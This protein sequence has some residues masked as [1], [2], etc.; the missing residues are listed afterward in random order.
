[1]YRKKLKSGFCSLLATL[2][3]GVFIF[4]ACS[5][6]TSEEFKDTDSSSKIDHSFNKRDG[7]SSPNNPSNPWD[8]YGVIHNEILQYVVNNQG[9]LGNDTDATINFALT[10]F[11]SRYDPMSFGGYTSV[12]EIQNILHSF[13]NS[14]HNV[15]STYS[16]SPNTKN[17]LRGL[18]DIIYSSFEEDDLDYN[19]M[20]NK[21]I[22]F[23]VNLLNGNSGGAVSVNDVDKIIILKATSIARHS[24]YFWYLNTNE[25]DG[26][27]FEYELE[28][29]GGN[30]VNKKWWKWLVIGAADVAGG[31]TGNVAGALGASAGASTL[32][33]EIS[34]EDQAP[35]TE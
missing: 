17:K 6:A 26:P 27:D 16:Y 4:N 1:M 21:I 10:Q 7:V 11:E 3:V 29:G 2:V 34:P 18:F 13:P 24:F 28:D 12:S 8:I 14:Y 9:S 31:V 20:K 22:D 15:I 33:D 30:R 19:S 35:P 32:V 23:E 25:I 5:E